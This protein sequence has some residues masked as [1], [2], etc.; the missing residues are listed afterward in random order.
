VFKVQFGKS[1][2]NDPTQVY[3]RVA[4]RTNVV[5]I[6]R[7]LAELVEKPYTEFRDRVLLSFRPSLVDRI[8]A[9]VLEEPKADQAT[10]AAETFAVQRQPQGDWR[11]VSPFDAPADRQLMQLF[12]EDLA[13]LEIIQ[14]GKEVVTDFA[15]YGLLNPIRQYILKTR[16]TNAAGVTNQT[17]LQV[18]FGASPPNEP[19]KV[20]CRRSDETSVYTVAFADMGRLQRAAFALRDRRIWTFASSNVTSLAIVQRGQR[21]EWTRNPVSRAWFRDDQVAHAAVEETLHRLGELQ[22]DAWVAR[23]EDQAKLLKVDGSEFQLAIHVSERGKTRPPLV[24]NLRLGM[25]GQPYGAVVLDEGQPVVFKFP[26]SLYALVVQY[27]SVPSAAAE[28]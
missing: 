26:A 17:L 8:E 20:Y 13:K 27:L 16:V 5:R 14:F 10:P 12:V 9:R 3:A 18:D 1:P 15:P 25:R 7:E 19:D 21:R 24:V 11:I 23:G 22:A 28:L 6:S 4:A 2:T